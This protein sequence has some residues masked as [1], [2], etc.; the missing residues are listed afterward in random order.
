M[1]TSRM[2]TID[3]RPCSAISP[4]CRQAAI[5]RRLPMFYASFA[6]DCACGAPCI[7]LCRLQEAL[8]TSIPHD[9]AKSRSRQHAHM[10][11]EPYNSH[12]IAELRDIAALGWICSIVCPGFHPKRSE[13]SGLDMAACRQ[14]RRREMLSGR[15][16]HSSDVRSCLNEWQTI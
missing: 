9:L 6:A 13:G 5:C 8:E 16:R 12:R 1:L 14:P 10:Y 2:L 11:R 4:C 7:R 15:R 3:G